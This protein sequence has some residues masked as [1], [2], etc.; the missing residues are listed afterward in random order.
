V[1]YAVVI[2]V[3]LL[4]M[5]WVIVRFVFTTAKTKDLSYLSNSSYMWLASFLWLVSQ[6]A[7]D[8]HI[9][10]QTNTFTMHTIGGIVAAL[11]FTYA[12]KSYQI[13]FE[14]WWQPWI[15]VFLFASGLGVLNELFEFFLYG[16]GVPGVVGG[17]EWWDLTANT[18]GASVAFTFVMIVSDD[19]KSN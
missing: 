12:V 6:V 19:V 1:I 16:I 15:G 17:D 2:P 10:D 18:I 3:L 4:F 14:A 11:L 8:I 9:S 5:P 13:K 7:P